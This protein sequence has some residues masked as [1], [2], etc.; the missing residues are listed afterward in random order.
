MAGHLH[1]ETFGLLAGPS[2]EFVYGDIEYDGRVTLYIIKGAY[3]NIPS[4]FNIDTVPFPTF[5]E[6]KGSSTQKCM[7]T[8]SSYTQPLPID[9]FDDSLMRTAFFAADET[10]YINYIK[11]F[12]L[13][14]LTS[15]V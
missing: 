7:C 4:G 8:C 2:G 13:L 12:L 3:S 6:L 9:E 15:S 10:S 1:H 5:P 14:S 11:P